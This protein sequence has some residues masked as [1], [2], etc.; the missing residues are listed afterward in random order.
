ME[1]GEKAAS[2]EKYFGERKNQK[3]ENED[4][5]NPV[6]GEFVKSKEAMESDEISKAEMELELAREKYVGAN[7]ETN[8]ALARIKKFLHLK[9]DPTNREEL[10]LNHSEY[11]NKLN[12]LL[13]LKIDELKNR[14]LG[15]DKIGEKMK[16]LLER[17]NLDEK[18]RLCDAHAKFEPQREEVSE[19]HEQIMPEKT[20]SVSERLPK[21]AKINFDSIF[22]G[23]AEEVIES[24]RSAIVLSG[25]WEDIKNMTF[26]EAA[27]ELKWRAN[28]KIEN[29]FKRL[30]KRL[31]DDA[32]PG[33]GETLE[34]WTERV[35]E[36]AVE[37]TK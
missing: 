35:A 25:K 7:F 11:K 4:I 5:K 31:G 16:D 10:N 28:K 6:K 26:S 30:K 15:N 14:N 18:S 17:F 9:S 2:I 8:S 37:K 29:I 23:D 27:R 20:G 21:P 32:R 19:N 24:F 22:R 3:P 12:E 34:K 13:N 1:K 36:L 33:D